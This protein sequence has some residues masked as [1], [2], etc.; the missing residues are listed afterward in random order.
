M[1]KCNASLR[2]IVWEA[3]KMVEV[4]LHHRTDVRQTQFRFSVLMVMTITP[5]VARH[6]GAQSTPFSWGRSDRNDHGSEMCN[7]K[8]RY[9]TV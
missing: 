8:L 7:V 9:A 3:I 5:V 4:A 2:R 6:L 1:R